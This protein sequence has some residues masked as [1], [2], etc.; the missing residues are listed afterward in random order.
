MSEYDA[1]DDHADE[2]EEADEELLS[3]VIYVRILSTR[4]PD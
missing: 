1:E 3:Q 2:E 4:Y